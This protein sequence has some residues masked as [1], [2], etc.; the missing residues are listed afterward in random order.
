[1]SLIIK[2]LGTSQGQTYDGGTGKTTIHR[3]SKRSDSLQ[4]NCIL[5]ERKDKKI[6][7]EMMDVFIGRYT[8]V[9]PDYKGFKVR[10]NNEMRIII[11]VGGWV[12][13]Y[14]KD[15]NGKEGRQYID[16]I[17]YETPR[18]RFHIPRTKRLTKKA[19]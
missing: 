5:K 11:W 10:Y 7:Q 16:S 14:I 4:F 8:T 15:A 17:S 6:L 12:S 9:L 3:G 18:R 19:A 1:M 2:E 13:I